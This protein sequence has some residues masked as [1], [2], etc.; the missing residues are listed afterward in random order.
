MAI[1]AT[2]FSTGFPPHGF[3]SVAGFGGAAGPGLGA[4]AGGGLSGAVASLGLPGGTGFSLSAG[5]GVGVRLCL[6]GAVVGCAL[7]ARREGTRWGGSW[8]AGSETGLRLPAGAGLATGPRTTGARFATAGGVGPR[9][10]SFAAEG[11]GCAG[12]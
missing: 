7:G 9:Q 4:R 6:G 5:G 8:L 1:L 2:F 3:D 10:T 12:A 11:F